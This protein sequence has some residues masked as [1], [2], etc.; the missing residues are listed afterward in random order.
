MDYCN[1]LYFAILNANDY[2]IITNYKYD[3]GYN[4]SDLLFGF[5]FERNNLMCVKSKYIFK[6]IYDQCIN[7]TND[8]YIVEIRLPTNELTFQKLKHY[9]N[10][11]I[12]YANS[13]IC[14]KK[15][16]LAEKETYELLSKY[17]IDLNSIYIFYFACKNYYVD[18][19][20]YLMSYN[21]GYQKVIDMALQNQD[22]DVIK[23]MAI[24][25]IGLNSAVKSA[26][27][28]KNIALVIE[29]LEEY[30][31]DIIS[32]TKQAIC[33]ED[34]ELLDYLC[35]NR[36]N[37]NIQEAAY[38]ALVNDKI[39]VLDYFIISHDVNV[40]ALLERFDKSNK[41]TNNNSSVELLKSKTQVNIDNNRP[42]KY[43]KKPCSDE[44]IPMTYDEIVGLAINTKMTSLMV[45]CNVSKNDNQ[46]KLVKT[47]VEL[48]M[49]IDIQNQFGR[50]ALMMACFHNN[51]KIINYLLDVS[52]SK[53]LR[54]YINI[55][56]YQ[57]MTA[58]MLVCQ[59]SESDLKL[60][61]VNLLLER[62]A[63]ISIKNKDN[64]SV[65]DLIH[66]KNNSEIEFLLKEYYYQ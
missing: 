62:G 28:F 40:N 56:D 17:D 46:F 33:C 64:Q 49:K 54:N 36:H 65:F 25:K 45:A 24:M 3:Y 14:S 35:L 48:G 22:I 20:R 34:F 31:S 55:Q 58:L 7:N 15:Y 38:Y 9:D 26:V 37:L 39:K 42:T 23:C 4:H 59:A 29:L 16:N 11:N 44:V 63:D 43:I 12:I 19:V 61:V 32:A 52:L 21:P 2:N 60:D 8:I 57:G 1:K 10:P 50:T 27:Y 30:G 47:F 5:D 41:S 6:H 66:G 18:V 51:I 53:N 13:I